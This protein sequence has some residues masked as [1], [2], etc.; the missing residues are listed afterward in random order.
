MQLLITGAAPTYLEIARAGSTFTAYTSP[1]GSTWTA[2]PGS[3]VTVASLTGTLPAG[4][5]VTS[6]NVTAVSTASF[7]SV[8]LGTNAPAPVLNQIQAIHVQ[9]TAATISWSTDTLADSQS[10]STGLNRRQFL[11]TTAV[12][13]GGMA[14]GF[15]LPG[16]AD[17][18]ASDA[19]TSC[20]P[21]S[22]TRAERPR[23]PES[24]RWRAN[25]GR[26]P[27]H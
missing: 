20:A 18:A 9:Q 23:S 13:G 21:S 11:T 17:A 4:M 27:A 1:D 24:R 10:E 3:S 7:D 16:K 26:R 19:S 22:T 2:V 14:L 12:V 5:A 25:A 15:W 6:H 8:T